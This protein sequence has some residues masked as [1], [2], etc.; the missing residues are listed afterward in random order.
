MKTVV[1]KM[2]DLEQIRRLVG[3]WWLVIG[4]WWLV[5]G[6]CLTA[7]KG[8][9][10]SQYILRSCCYLNEWAMSRQSACPHAVLFSQKD[11]SS[12][13]GSDP[14]KQCRLRLARNL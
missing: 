4:D 8:M 12:F 14:S 5:V 3:G 2:R 9:R 13:L 11:L 6:G 7:D 10:L 1:V